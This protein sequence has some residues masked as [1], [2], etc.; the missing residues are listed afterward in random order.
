M[1][2]DLTIRPTS[3]IVVYEQA[4][5]SLQIAYLSFWNNGPFH[6]DKRSKER[7]WK[8][9][10]YCQTRPIFKKSD[11]IYHYAPVITSLA[12]SNRY[13][14]VGKCETI[15][16]GLFSYSISLYMYITSHLITLKQIPLSSIL[17]LKTFCFSI[18]RSE[19]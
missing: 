12:L 11:S 6:N 10:L 3:F 8:T 2:S 16:P 13:I 14:G 19:P 15:S 9:I 4:H 7:F 5:L 18:I 1:T 17:R